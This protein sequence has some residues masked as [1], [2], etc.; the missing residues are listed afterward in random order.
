MLGFSYFSYLIRIVVFSTRY[1]CLD[2]CTVLSG[3]VFCSFCCCDVFCRFVRWFF[4]PCGQTW[5][6]CAPSPGCWH[7]SIVCSILFLSTVLWS[8]CGLLGNKEKVHTST[9]SDHKEWKTSG[10][11]NKIRHNNKN[12]RKLY[13]TIPYNNPD[14][15]IRW[16]T[17][18]SLSNRKNRRTPTS[19]TIWQWNSQPNIQWTLTHC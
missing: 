18:Q 8:L 13:L 2:C 3:K 10:Q 9:K 19:A 16:K 12:C 15:D 6:M 7:C 17:Q 11:N 4:I 1:R 5:W 14:S